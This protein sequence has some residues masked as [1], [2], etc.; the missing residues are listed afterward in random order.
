GSISQTTYVQRLI[1][2][3]RKQLSPETGLYASI[4]QGVTKFTASAGQAVTIDVLPWFQSGRF[5]V[6][7]QPAPW[8]KLTAGVEG[9]VYPFHLKL[10]GQRPPG[11]GEVPTPTS[12]QQQLTRDANDWEL[13]AGV[14]AEAALR[15]GGLTITPGVRADY[16]RL[17]DSTVV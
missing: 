16:Y 5:E 12:I 17:I 14:Y 13:R 9:Q 11:E 10:K 8:L 1:A 7:Q 6:A 4:A 15:A 2:T 3:F